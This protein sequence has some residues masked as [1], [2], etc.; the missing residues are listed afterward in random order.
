M[1]LAELKEFIKNAS[2][3]FLTFSGLYR[4]I[5]GVP[6]QSITNIIIVSKVGSESCQILIVAKPARVRIPHYRFNRY[7]NNRRRDSRCGFWR[8]RLTT[9]KQRIYFQRGKMRTYRV[10]ILGCRS[11]GT[12]AAR[13]YHAH[14]RTKVV[15]LCDLIEDRLNTLGDEA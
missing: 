7:E 12:S 11:R 15:G 6:V 8:Q 1:L 14:P 5:S 2:K 10:A 13:A 3:F 9:R 4:I